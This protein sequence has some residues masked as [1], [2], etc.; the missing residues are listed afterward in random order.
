MQERTPKGLYIIL[1]ICIILAALVLFLN[2][3]IVFSAEAPPFQPHTDIIAI[4]VSDSA[5]V[6]EYEI[7]GWVQK[8]ENGVRALMIEKTGHKID[9]YAAKG[10]SIYL[11]DS[12]AAKYVPPVE[13]KWIMEY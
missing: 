3:E 9:T 6:I 8:E 10:D 7:Y 2:R 13:E 12:K 11:K 1:A 5:I 4:S